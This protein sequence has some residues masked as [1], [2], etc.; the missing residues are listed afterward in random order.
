[1]AFFSKKEKRST[2]D[3][4]FDA[5]VS[6]GTNDFANSYAG[7]YALKNSDVYTAT[8][9][10]ASDI[11]SNP[12]QLTTNNIVDANSDLNYLLNVKPNDL[13]DG[14]HFKFALAANMLLNGNSYARII[15]DKQGN[16]LR[17][18]FL[19]VSS[20]SITS[21]GW[22]ITYT[23]RD[24][25]GK[26]IKLSQNDVLH[27]KFVSYDGLTGISPLFALK[28]EIQMQTAG[29]NTLLS[30][31]KSGVN[32]SGILKVKG[33]NLSPE[34]KANIR[35]K[36]EEA[37]AGDANSLRTII[38]DDGFEY[39]PIEINTKVLELVNNNVYTTK[40]IAKVFGIPL[41]RFGMELT[42]TSSDQ[43]NLSYLQ[44]TLSHYFSAFTSELNV[45]LLS[46]PQNRVSQFKFDTNRLLEISTD[47]LIE[48][49]NR[50]VQGSLMTINEARAKMGLAPIENGDR[51]MA[52]LNYT[53]LDS[54]EMHQSA[55]QNNNK[56]F[57]NALLNKGG[58][59]DD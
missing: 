18:D 33:G 17:L 14:W 2:G 41:E 50:A 57:I 59:K 24:D 47:K 13:T 36:F 58:E 16:P 4:F 35:E 3:P 29:N 19:P 54:L 43:A 48:S 22:S 42:N 6:F 12:I 44:N 27:F 56:A 49:L 45:K 11:A 5:V 8:K 21:D 52:N 26:Q 38:L 46:Y 10:I 15:R 40:Q 37:N 30:F 23:Y 32:G 31:F 9:I 20:V 1:M 39:T 34:A 55:N 7:I 51:M 28:K 25:D 53:M